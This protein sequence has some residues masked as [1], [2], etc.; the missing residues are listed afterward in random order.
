MQV[1][2]SGNGELSDGAGG[3]EKD[4]RESSYICQRLPYII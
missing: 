4:G 2:F 3:A 1:L